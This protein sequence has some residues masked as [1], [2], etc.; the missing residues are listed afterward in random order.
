MVSTS[1][2]KTFSG[3]GNETSS[4][5]TDNSAYIATYCGLMAAGTVATIYRTFQFFAFCLSAS[6]AIHDD[7]F[8]SIMRA[9]M[10]FFDSNPSGRILNR[11]SKDLINMESQLTQALIELIIVR[12]GVPRKHTSMSHSNYV[13]E[14]QFTLELI[15]SVVMVSIIVNCWMLIPCIVITIFFCVLRYVFTNTAQC[16]QRIEAICK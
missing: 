3:T 4:D 14:F 1:K 15:S 6:I 2:I 12:M 9:K 7:L 11:F 8:V 10:S 13:H 16:V 5:L